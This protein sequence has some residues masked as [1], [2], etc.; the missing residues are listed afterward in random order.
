MWPGMN[1]MAVFFKIS[2][3]VKCYSKSHESNFDAPCPER[4]VVTDESVEAGHT[5][6][7]LVPMSNMR[8]ER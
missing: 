5:P 8:E 7:S 6:D 2:I 1:F 4:L 3:L